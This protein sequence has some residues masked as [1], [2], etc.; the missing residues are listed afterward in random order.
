MQLVLK[1][2]QDLLA[3]PVKT[4]LSAPSDL[5]DCRGSQAKMVL[6]DPRVRLVRKALREKMGRSVRKESRV[7][8]VPQVLKDGRVWLALLARMVLSDRRVTLA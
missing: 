4:E 3:L 2:P 8:L 5:K 6:L 1:A 7:I